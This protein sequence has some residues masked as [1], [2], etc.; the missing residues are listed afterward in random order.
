MDKTS[1]TK[2][3]LQVEVAPS[4]DVVEKGWQA[5]KSFIRKH[6]WAKLFLVIFAI[7]FIFI[8][9]QVVTTYMSVNSARNQFDNR[10]NNLP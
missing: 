5:Q 10:L 1:E 7:F 9:Y 4:S 2:Q 3:P 8:L 6:W